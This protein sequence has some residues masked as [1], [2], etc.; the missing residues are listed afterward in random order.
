MMFPLSCFFASS[1]CSRTIR[2]RDIFCTLSNSWV[3]TAGDVKQSFSSVTTGSDL[4][5]A[6]NDLEIPYKVYQCFHSHLIQHLFLNLSQCRVTPEWQYVAQVEVAIWEII[7]N[8]HKLDC[9]NNQS[10]TLKST[11]SFIAFQKTNGTFLI[12][13]N[14]RCASACSLVFYMELMMNSWPKENYLL[15]DIWKRVRPIFYVF[16][17]SKLLNY[18][19]YAQL[20]Y[21]VLFSFLF[22]EYAEWLRINNYLTKFWN[23]ETT[24]LPFLLGTKINV[25]AL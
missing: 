20:S 16:K 10:P 1:I 23:L 6:I 12:Y 5:I 18:L 21:I 8:K 7:A 25:L 22:F 17:E 14:R 19:M 13:N 15:N 3:K 4:Y 11:Y 24:K 9:S 2:M